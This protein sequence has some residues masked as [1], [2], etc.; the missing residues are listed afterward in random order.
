MA[1]LHG[2]V[3]FF[4]L[5]VALSSFDERDRGKP[6]ALG[7]AVILLLLFTVAVFKAID[8]RSKQ[9]QGNRSHPGR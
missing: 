6:M 4:V 8:A 2:F 7:I 5:A 1:F 9:F 3:N